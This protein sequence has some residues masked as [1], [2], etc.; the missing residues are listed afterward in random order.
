VRA[1]IKNNHNAAYKILGEYGAKK[2]DKYIVVDSLN[3]TTHE[4]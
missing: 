4:Y 1:L 3:I 2:G